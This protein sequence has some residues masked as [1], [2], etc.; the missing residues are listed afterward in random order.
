MMRG[1]E[2]IPSAEWRE[3]ARKGGSA[4]YAESLFENAGLDRDG[5]YPD[6]VKPLHYDPEAI[7][8]ITRKAIPRFQLVTFKLKDEELRVATSYG[9]YKAIQYPIRHHPEILLRCTYLTCHKEAKDG[10]YIV[11]AIPAR[12]IIKKYDQIQAELRQSS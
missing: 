9:S 7:A 2:R 11:Y 6:E 3:I 8:F 1:T 12:L 4:A 10:Y 5:F